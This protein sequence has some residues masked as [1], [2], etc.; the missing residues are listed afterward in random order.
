MAPPSRTSF[1][2][3]PRRDGHGYRALKGCCLSI[4]L[5][6]AQS[7]RKR[8]KIYRRLHCGCSGNEGGAKTLSHDQMCKTRFTTGLQLGFYKSAASSP[9]HLIMMVQSQASSVHLRFRHSSLSG[10]GVRTEVKGV[11]GTLSVL[12]ALTHPMQRS[13]D[14]ELLALAEYG[15]RA[16]AVERVSRYT[17]GPPSI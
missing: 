10:G 7:S 13:F 11:L 6:L 1:P 14:R 2:R 15:L 3:R 5:F 16:L 4:R 9:G 12:P 17:Q 8:H